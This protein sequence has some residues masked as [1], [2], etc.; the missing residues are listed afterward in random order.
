MAYK[1]PEQTAA[2]VLIPLGFILVNKTLLPYSFTDKEGTTFN[3]MADF[4]HAGLDLWVEI[5]CGHLNGKT[6]VANAKRAYERLDP[7][8]L[9]RYA[10][11][12]QITTQWNHSSVKHALVQS[13]IGAPQYAIVFTKQPDDDTLSRIAKQG[14]QAFSLKRFANI[15]NLQ[16]ACEPV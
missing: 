6:S 13:T 2:A 10:S 11:H 15:V 5:K 7:M 14:I 4:Y 12:C 8:K 9:A 16:L 3:A 1:T